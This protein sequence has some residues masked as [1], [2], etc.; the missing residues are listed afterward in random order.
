MLTKITGLWHY[1]AKHQ[2]DTDIYNQ[3]FTY[4]ILPR[5]IDRRICRHLVLIYH[6]TPWTDHF[7]MCY[8]LSDWQNSD[9][10]SSRPEGQ[11]ITQRG[12]GVP[13]RWYANVIIAAKIQVRSRSGSSQ[14]TT[15]VY[16]GTVHLPRLSTNDHICLRACADQV[17][18]QANA[19][20]DRIF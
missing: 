16:C 15:V 12:N 10:I 5:C 13:K 1:V 8:S 14:C 20:E 11:T 7:W 19:F 2:R 9:N 4:G 17:V 3:P 18:R 6:A